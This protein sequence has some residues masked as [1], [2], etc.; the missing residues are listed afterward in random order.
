MHASSKIEM[1]L[2]LDRYMSKSYD[3]NL[4]VLDVGSMDVNGSYRDIVPFKWSYQGVDLSEGKNVNVVMES[5]FSI[6]FSDSEFDLVITGQCLEHCENPFHLM[7]E[8]ARV[9][10]GIVIATAP[11]SWPEH[12][13]P[14]DY[15]R[16]M[17]DGMAEIM[18]KAGLKVIETYIS[19]ISKSNTKGYDCW[20]V[21]TC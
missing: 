17:P 1:V 5:P 3:K 12:N 8:I 20:G 9:A 4:R 10:R 21:A 2:C 14:K 7:K 16:F 11:G 6:P 13:Y 15:F 18:N 19:D